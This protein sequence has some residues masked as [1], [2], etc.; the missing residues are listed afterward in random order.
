M[1]RVARIRTR[2]LVYALLA[3]A[4][5]VGWLVVRAGSADAAARAR[6]VVQAKNAELGK[7]VL[8]TRKG[9]T[10]YSLS[11]ERRGR[12]ICTDST[13]L[14]FW[15]PLVVRKGTMPTG[16]AGLGTIRRPDGRIQ[17]TYHGGL[18]YVFYGDHQR[19]D[20]GGE[21]FKDVGVWHAATVTK[22]M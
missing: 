8:V 19:G 16:V 12:F 13:C 3:V 2:I 11:V 14:T 20:V 6:V 22:R 15:T 18:L 21:G 7:T 9:L 10:L 5:L 17:V 4:L 1:I